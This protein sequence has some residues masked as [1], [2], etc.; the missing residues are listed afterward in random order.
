M[1]QTNRKPTAFAAI[2]KFAIIVL[3]AEVLVRLFPS[4]RDVLYGVGLFLGIVI[5]LAIPPRN[6][7]RKQ[8]PVM[9]L[10]AAMVSAVGYLIH[11]RPK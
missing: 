10:I 6:M 5:Q 4:H 11:S 1:D 2:A 7:W 9:M 3:S 8:I